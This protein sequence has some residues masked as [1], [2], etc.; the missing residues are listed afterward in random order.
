M[1]EL[2]LRGREPEAARLGERR[3]WSPRARALRATAVYDG[4]QLGAGARLEGPAIVELA[5]TTVVVLE[6]FDLTVDR[7][8][9]FVVHAGEA[10]ADFARRL[11]AGASPTPVRG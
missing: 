7:F 3:A 6:G 5:N 8:G 11:V 1:T 9:S 2:A 4:E 10:G